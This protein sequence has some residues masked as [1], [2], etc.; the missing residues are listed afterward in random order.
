MTAN[1]LHMPIARGGIVDCSRI[2]IVL[3]ED[4]PGIRP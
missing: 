3:R 4:A 2:D 1:G